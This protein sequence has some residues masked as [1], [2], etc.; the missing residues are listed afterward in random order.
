MGRQPS[1][2]D[3]LPDDIRAKLQELLRDPRVTQLEATA[4]INAILETEGHDDRI[5]KSA[6]NRYAIRME[7]AGAKIRESREVAEMWI[8]QLGATPQGKVG[9]FVNETLRTLALDIS[10]VLQEGQLN[11]KN[12]PKAAKMLNNLAL[13]MQRLEKAANLNVER[14]K[15]IRQEERE[16]A[17][18]QAAK[19]A[20]KGGLS[21]DT[22][23]EIRR[24][25]L[26]ITS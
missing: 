11:G 13:A 21:S 4:K 25:I 1:T 14:E 20:K 9:N 5:S 8:G 3:Q 2:I 17:A 23:Q 16:R 26:G 7:Q 24:Q 19:I 10:L 15:E 18:D 22:V 6:V 12:A